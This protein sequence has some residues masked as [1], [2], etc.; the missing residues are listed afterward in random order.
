MQQAAGGETIAQAL[1]ERH[2][3]LSLLR[4][5]GGDVPL[6]GV[7]FVDAHEGRFAA[8]GEPHVPFAQVRV[9]A[10]TERIDRLP[11]V[12]RIWQGDAWRF[13]EPR[14][15]HVMIELFDHLVV[16]V[17]FVPGIR[18]CDGG[19]GLRIGGASERNMSL[20]RH[21]ARGRIQTDPAGAGHE[22]L[23]PG[24]QI[25]EVGERTF[26]AVE[27]LFVGDELN[28]VSGAEPRRE[29]EVPAQL[30]QKPGR[31]AART[32]AEVERFLRSLHARFHADH[33]AH[34]PIHESIQADEVIVHRLLGPPLARNEFAQPRTG[35]ER[36]EIRSQFVLQDGFVS[37]RIL[38][39]GFFHE[40]FERVDGGEVG[41]EIDR[42]GEFPRGFREHEP[43]DVVAVWVLLPVEKVQL[44]LDGE[45]VTED[46]SAGVRRG[47]QSHHVRQN[48]HGAIVLVPRDM[49]ECDANA[50]DGF[51][52]KRAH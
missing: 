23:R 32:P 11:L 3:L 34:V 52:A 27:W 51:L 29:S 15:R 28:E 49:S 37:Q 36:F 33:V 43:G 18:T 22:H 41:D 17:H 30:H 1:H 6:G 35:R 31:I 47:P 5:E 26:R 39:G 19:R 7:A 21:Q 10:A 46:R 48:G 40:E 45:R 2:A 20:G 14:H 44:R 38:L 24:V 4:A 13:A 9:D 42:D 12:V 16:V 50:H 8:H 25:G